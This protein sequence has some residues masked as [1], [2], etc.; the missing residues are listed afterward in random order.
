MFLNE[1]LVL[2]DSVNLGVLEGV[3]YGWHHNVN[4]VKR[5]WLLKALKVGVEA[6]FGRFKVS[7]SDSETLRIVREEPNVV[8]ALCRKYALR[9]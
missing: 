4:D 2:S 1:G 8:F 5:L 6:I 3:S 7:V 9:M